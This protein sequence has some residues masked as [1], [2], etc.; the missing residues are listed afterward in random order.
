[1]GIE[2][3]NALSKYTIRQLYKPLEI[4]QFN[5]HTLILTASLSLLIYRCSLQTIDFQA[6]W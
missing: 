4:L 3:H 2:K 5:V 1:M 6:D